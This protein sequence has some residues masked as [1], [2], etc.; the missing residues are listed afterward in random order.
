V[1]DCIVFSPA[2]RQCHNC[3]AGLMGGD[4]PVA[5]HIV[6]DDEAA[7]SVGATLAMHSRKL[8]TETHLSVNKPARQ[9]QT[10]PF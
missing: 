3:L 8:P 9:P 2:V 1:R 6:L 7:R 10:P 5:I 4:N